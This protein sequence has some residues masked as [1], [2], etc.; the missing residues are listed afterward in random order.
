MKLSD[1]MDSYYRGVPGET[2]FHEPYLRKVLDVDDTFLMLQQVHN[3]QDERAYVIV[4]ALVAESRLDKLLNLLLPTFN[5]ENE[6][7]NR[8]VELLDAFRII[9]RHLLQAARLLQSIRNKFAHDLEV[10]GF[11]ELI[12]KYPKF[13]ENL[14]TFCG[15]RNLRGAQEDDVSRMFD[16]VSLLATA[17][18]NRYVGN[19]RHYVELTRSKG[20]IDAIGLSHE[21]ERKRLLE[22]VVAALRQHQAAPINDCSVT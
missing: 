12:K 14:K 3:T 7:T 6:T 15:Q 1:L 5:L 8:K 2:L 16:E 10:G 21:D 22:V 17:G 19:V 9:P 4:A 13:R 18:L 11:E 20:F